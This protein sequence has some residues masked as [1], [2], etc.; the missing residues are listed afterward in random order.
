MR[1]NPKIT[2][3]IVSHNARHYIQDCLESIYY[4][5]YPRQCY[6]VVLVDNNSA[7]ST[8]GFVKEMFP[9]VKVIENRTNRG[10]AEANNQGYFLAR[11]NQAD[12]LVLLNQDTIVSRE[13]LRH[14]VDLAESKPKTAAFQPK[15][16]LYP[17]TTKINSFGNRIHF[18][19]FAYCDKYR[20]PD[21]ERQTAP[22]D[23]AYPSGAACLLRMS[24]LAE[25][26]LLDERLFMYHEDVDLG[27]RLRLAGYRVLFDPLAVVYHKYS[28]SKAKYKFYY[29]E[30]NRLI[31]CLET[32]RVATLIILF[33]AWL[34]MELGLLAFALKNH[35]LKEK[36][37]GYRWILFHWPSIFSRRLDYQFKF[38]RVKDRQLIRLF[39]GSIEFQEVS[40]F[41]LTYVVNPLMEA[42]LW[43]VK[44]IIF[45]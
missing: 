5:N 42:Y 34:V 45:W 38:R 40:Y 23:I 12:Y 33:P 10:F 43:L 27:W 16:L 1:S 29:M 41:P 35:W 22:F 44:K 15:L 39:T 32:Y 36:L 7:D 21:R 25:V 31:V 19:G 26:G 17:E 6:R 28:F 11:K 30:R 24:A 37:K 9:W 14:L 2:I 4:Q 8:V 3:V 18:L 20:W 13:W